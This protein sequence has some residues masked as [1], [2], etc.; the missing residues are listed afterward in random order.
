MQEVL[1]GGWVNAESICFAVLHAM[2]GETEGSFVL[3]L[4]KKQKLLEI[5]KVRRELKTAKSSHDEMMMVDV[6]CKTPKA[7]G[8]TNK[9]RN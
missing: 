1:S 4:N 6:R 5:P 7:I 3:S 8:I 9:R 2:A